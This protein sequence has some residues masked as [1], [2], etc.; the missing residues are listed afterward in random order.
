MASNAWAK[1]TVER[2]T[3]TVRIGGKKK[4]SNGMVSGYSYINKNGK[5][6]HVPPRRN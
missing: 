2:S 6:V 3:R 4:K 5:V 1:Q